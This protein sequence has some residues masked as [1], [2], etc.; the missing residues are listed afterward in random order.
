MDINLFP[1]LSLLT[2]LPKENQTWMKFMHLWQLNR[3]FLP[4]RENIRVCPGVVAILCQLSKKQ[5]LMWSH[6]RH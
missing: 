2:G 1:G 3:N 5:M 6:S 4:H